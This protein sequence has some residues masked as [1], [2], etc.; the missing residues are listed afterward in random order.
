MSHLRQTVSI[1]K[2]RQEAYKWF[3]LPLVVL[4][5]VYT[6]S[7][8]TGRCAWEPLRLIPDS[9]SMLSSCISQSEERLSLEISTNILPVIRE[10][11]LSHGEKLSLIQPPVAI[12]IA[13]MTIDC[14]TGSFS[15]IPFPCQPVVMDIVTQTCPT[16]ALALQR[17][18]TNV[19][20]Y[21]VSRTP[22]NKL[23]K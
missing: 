6:S 11:S 5:Y 21:A 9:I 12:T 18:C 15:F 16:T 17:H 22:A 7:I 10:L 20:L 2:M 19:L 4:T 3:I 8:V 1:T 14:F 13:S 23:L